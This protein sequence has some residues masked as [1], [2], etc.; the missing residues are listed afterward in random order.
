[1]ATN[2]TIDRL[3]SQPSMYDQL[4]TLGVCVDAEACLS[5]TGFCWVNGLDVAMVA[6]DMRSD[7]RSYD[8]E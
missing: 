7:M 5:I 6:F 8:D 4:E 2:I 3:R 1:M